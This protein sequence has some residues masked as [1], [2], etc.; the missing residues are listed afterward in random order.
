MDLTYATIPVFGEQRRLYRETRMAYMVSSKD[1]P[2]NFPI[3]SFDT[4]LGS[5]ILFNESVGDESKEMLSENKCQGN[6]QEDE[7]GTMSWWSLY[8][9]GLAGREGAGAGIWIT[10]PNNE[11]KFFSYKL[12]FDCTNNMAEYKY[13][14]LGLEALL[15]LK[16]RNVVVCGDSELVIKQV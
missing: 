13:L 11:S 15:K 8:F 12:N 7:K 6:P 4:G 10:S 1:K 16:A 14:I 2:Q 3:Y 9:D 5:A